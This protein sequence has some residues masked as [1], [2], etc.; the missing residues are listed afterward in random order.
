MR[1]SV[2]SDALGPFEP[3]GPFFLPND[4]DD[5]ML[6][7][8]ED[9]E[10]LGA[11]PSGGGGKKVRGNYNCG[12]CGLPK[13]GHGARAPAVGASPLSPA[14]HCPAQP[15][16]ARRPHVPQPQPARRRARRVS[17]MMMMSCHV[18]NPR[19]PAVLVAAEEVQC[20]RGGGVQLRRHEHARARRVILRRRCAHGAQADRALACARKKRN[21]LRASCVVQQARLRACT[22]LRSGPTAPR[23]RGLSPR[24]RPAP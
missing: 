1:R 16:R 22:R 7:A 13:R 6:E 5:V 4:D 11:A 20:A 8:D 2:Y 19:A 15:G 17:G 3:A 23:R 10:G 21:V 18:W 9:E 14:N 12:K 24:A